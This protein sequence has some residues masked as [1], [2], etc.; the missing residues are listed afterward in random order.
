MVE[1]HVGCTAADTA[2]EG[3]EFW[4][5]GRGSG[6]QRECDVT[7]R[8]APVATFKHGHILNCINSDIEHV[9]GLRGTFYMVSLCCNVRFFSWC[10]R[11][12]NRWNVLQR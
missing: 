11:Y 2:R 12:K 10:F 8:G 4:V 1:L 6:G 5:M 3:L 7:V 9:P